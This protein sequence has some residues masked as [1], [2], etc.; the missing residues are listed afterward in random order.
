MLP[1]RLFNWK[2]GLI[3]ALIL[4]PIEVFGAIVPCTPSGIIDSNGQPQIVGQCTINDLFS[5][6]VMIFNFLLGLSALVLMLM[7]V[8]SGIRI[9]VFYI[10]ESPESE[11]QSAK[12]SLTRALFG[13]GIVVATYL[14]IKTLVFVVF[15]ADSSG[16]GVNSVFEILREFGFFR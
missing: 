14:I 4:V 12:L 1:K 6:P 10:S 2:V 7:I 11:L 8:W 16:T 3:W 13:F 15:G 5:I 9:A